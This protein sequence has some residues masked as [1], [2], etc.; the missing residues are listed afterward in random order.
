M[1]AKSHYLVVMEHNFAIVVHFAY[2]RRRE[3]DIYLSGLVWFNVDEV[4]GRFQIKA[5]V[6]CVG[7]KCLEA[8][9]EGKRIRKLNG[10]L[11]ISETLIIS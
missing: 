11:D 1:T 2:C 3:H 4:V 7:Y 6:D 9:G 5:I 8:C 10:M